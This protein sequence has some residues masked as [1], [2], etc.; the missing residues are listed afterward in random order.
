M[1]VS[2]IFWPRL[3]K[4]TAE[5]QDKRTRGKATTTK[6]DAAKKQLEVLK[7]RRAEQQPQVLPSE[8]E[9]STS[10]PD[11]DGGA[12]RS[13]KSETNEDEE[14][15]SADSIAHA[16]T[17]NLDEYEEDFVVEDED[18]LIGAPH[19]LNEIP[20]EF[21]RHAHKKP[22]EYF[23]DIVEWMVHNKLNPAFARDDPLYRVA[24]A[25][26]DD[27]ARSYSSSQFLSAAWTGDFAKALKA[28]PEMLD[29][30]I[31][32]MPEHK[33]DACNRSGH[34]PKFRITFLGKAYHRQTL[35]DVS[36]D[37]EDDDENGDAQSRDSKGNSI[38]SSEMVFFVGKSVV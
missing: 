36:D 13:S 22:K 31:D 8:S 25:K 3:T 7:R 38:P 6:K 16:A 5:V 35:E 15:S 26:L 33:C 30:A 2:G 21:T 4:F 12:A 11:G 14:D 34:P 1:I 32:A 28:R 23:K 17:E 20:I 9:T 37:E 19:S 10:D 18:S 24:F 27:V 29:V